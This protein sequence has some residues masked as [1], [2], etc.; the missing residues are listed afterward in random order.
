LSGGRPNGKCRAVVHEALR[1]ELRR[2][3]IAGTAN[4][5]EAA[6]FCFVWIVMP[7]KS[8]ESV[9]AK[10]ARD[11]APVALVARKSWRSDWRRRAGCWRGQ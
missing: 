8:H 1:G 2:P 4:S 10:E 3:R 6:N 7:D 11:I 9:A 5:R